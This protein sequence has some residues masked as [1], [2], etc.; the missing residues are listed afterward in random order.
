MTF[1]IPQSTISIECLALTLVLIRP[2]RILRDRDRIVRQPLIVHAGAVRIGVLW[3]VG[4][5]ALDGSLLNV[6]IVSLCWML[7]HI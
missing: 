6:R 7:R 2:E 1:S 3:L 4:P 5:I